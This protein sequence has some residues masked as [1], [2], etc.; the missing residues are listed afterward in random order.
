MGVSQVAVTNRALRKI[1]VSTLAAPT[2]T[3]AQARTTLDLFETVARTELRK[4]PWSFALAKAV[5]L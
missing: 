5:R 1:G 4:H 2:D 3:S